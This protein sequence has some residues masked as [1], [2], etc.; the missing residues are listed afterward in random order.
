MFCMQK[1][2]ILF[3]LYRGKWR[4]VLH[5]AADARDCPLHKAEA[6]RSSLGCTGL[7]CSAGPPLHGLC[8]LLKVHDMR[9]LCCCT[10]TMRMR[11]PGTRSRCC[12]ASCPPCRQWDSSRS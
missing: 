8:H 3:S 9:T 2:L 11:L 5:G 10:C 6:A 12:C 7:V 4:T 1:Q